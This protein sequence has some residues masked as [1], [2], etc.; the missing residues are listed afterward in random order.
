MDIL[1]L[2]IQ[3]VDDPECEITTI[4]YI[5]QTRCFVFRQEGICIVLTFEE[6]DQLMEFAGEFR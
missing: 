1:T 4:Q 5:E 6:M 2:T 3:E